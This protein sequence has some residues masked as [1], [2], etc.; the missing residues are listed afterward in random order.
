MA[1]ISYRP[2]VIDTILKEALEASGAVWLQG[3]KWCGKT[4]TARQ[5]AR[6]FLMMQDP[7]ESTNY[8]Q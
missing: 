6:S 2:R 1:Q 8:L 4:W 3:P 5:M 7:D